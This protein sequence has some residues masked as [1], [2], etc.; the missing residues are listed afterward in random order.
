MSA[1]QEATRSYH[2]KFPGLF[3]AVLGRTGLH[4]SR[5]GFGS[6]RVSSGVEGH[7]MALRRALTCGINLIDTSANYADGASEELIGETLAGLFRDGSVT[8]EQVVLVSKGG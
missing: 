1:E 4:V 2:E 5:A 7:A 3:S 6:Y 8:R